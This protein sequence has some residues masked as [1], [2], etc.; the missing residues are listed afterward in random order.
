MTKRLH[1]FIVSLLTAMNSYASIGAIS[2]ATGGT[3]RGAIEPIDGVLLNPASI[4]DLPNNN[5]SYNYSNN[6]WAITVSDNGHDSYIPAAFI[7][8]KTNTDKLDT[9]QTGLVL[10]TRRWKKMTLSATASIIEYTQQISTVNQLKHRQSAVDI[11]STVALGNNLGLGLVFNKVSSSDVTLDPNQQL[12]KTMALGISYTYQS[13]ARFR[14]DVES[15]PDNKTERLVHMIGLENYLNDW[16]VF[17]L[18]YQNNNVISKNYFS[19]GFGFAGPQFG[20]HYAY[21]SNTR[22]SGEEKHCIDLGFP[23]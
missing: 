2:T 7:Y 14:Y 8:K 1:I 4:S 19:A 5:F 9:Q 15:S 11:A 23:F 6:E 13:F 22:D 20:L 3:G 16:V 21:V 18:G 12:Q 10:S 17:R